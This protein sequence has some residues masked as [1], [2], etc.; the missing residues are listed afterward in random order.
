MDRGWFFG[1][2]AKNYP[3]ITKI[4]GGY[5]LGGGGASF[6]NSMKD[7]MHACIHAHAHACVH[8]CIH[9]HAYVH[10]YIH[11]YIRTYVRT[12]VSTDIHTNTRAKTHA[13]TFYV[14][15]SSCTYKQICKSR[16]KCMMR[17]GS[18][19]ACKK[20]VAWSSF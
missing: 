7:Y 4:R 8:T 17:P 12:Y 6:F 5:Y 11:P 18:R 16:N 9:Q 14:H 19:D 20:S 10:T 3:L 1:T 2:S 13:H 15:I